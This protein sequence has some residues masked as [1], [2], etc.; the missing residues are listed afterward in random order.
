MDAH[1]DHKIEYTERLDVARINS[2]LRFRLIRGW[3]IGSGIHKLRA[4]VSD[5]VGAMMNR[6]SEVVKGRMGSLMKSFMAS[7]NG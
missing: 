7:A 6:D 1:P 4:S 5:R 2:I 3:G